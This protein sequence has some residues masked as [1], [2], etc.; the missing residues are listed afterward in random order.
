[1]TVVLTI[2][3][4]IVALRLLASASRSRRS[5]ARELQERRLRQGPL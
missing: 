1:M 4:L 3:A 5:P 2:A